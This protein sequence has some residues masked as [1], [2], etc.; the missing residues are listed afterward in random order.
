MDDGLTL[1]QATALNQYLSETLGWSAAAQA[2]VIGYALARL[3]QSCVTQTNRSIG[4]LI[5][6]EAGTL[7]AFIAA[8]RL[9]G[10]N[11]QPIVLL[12]YPRTELSDDA[13]RAATAFEALN[14][15]VFEPGAPLPPADLWIDAIAVTK[16]AE[17]LTESVRQLIDA[18]NHAGTSIISLSLPSGLDPVTGKATMPCI[19]AD[20]T[21]VSGLPF[22]GLLKSFAKELVGELYV[23]DSGLPASVWRR[24]GVTDA[25]TF[26]GKPYVRWNPAV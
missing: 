11:Y 17:P 14:G 21:L 24:I 6:R 8:R 1:E 25:P 15:R 18:V 3:A 10:W 19:R 13:E 4:V 12:S 5:G 2:E 22:Q 26:E 9:L 20:A 23:A 7:G 16:L